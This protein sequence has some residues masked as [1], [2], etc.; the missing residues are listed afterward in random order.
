MKERLSSQKDAKLE[1]REIKVETLLPL[2][3]SD[4]E[5]DNTGF[6]ED[7]SEDLNT[8]NLK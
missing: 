5:C 7:E 6:Q 8:Q 1:P 2:N 4:V 3:D